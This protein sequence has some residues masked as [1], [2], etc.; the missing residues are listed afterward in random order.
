MTRR[1]LSSPMTAAFM[2]IMPL[3]MVWVF[4]GMVISAATL[5]N[6]PLNPIVGFVVVTFIA[7]IGF[8]YSWQLRYASTDGVTL[9]LWS[10]HGRENVALSKLEHVAAISRGRSP[11]IEI[12]YP[13]DTQL[14]QEIAIIPPMGFSLRAFWDAYEF[15]ASHAKTA[16]R[17]GQADPGRP[18]HVDP[19][20]VAIFVIWLLV[21]LTFGLLFIYARS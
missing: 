14:K 18:K 13:S 10:Y 6:P 15:L 5:R 20:R 12:T 17:D 19:L 16:K 21:V 7:I 4:A 8:R 9:F 3:F 1:S 11:R 2:F